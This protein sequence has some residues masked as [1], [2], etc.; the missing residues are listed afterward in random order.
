L[1]LS[2]L[3]KGIRRGLGNETQQAVEV[4]W[5]EPSSLL[6]RLLVIAL[7]DI[8]VADLPTLYA[9]IELTTRRSWRRRSGDC[10]KSEV[11]RLVQAMCAAT[12]SR[13]ADELLAIATLEP[14]LGLSR[15]ELQHLSVPDR[16]VRLEAARSDIGH[17]ALCAWFQAGTRR[18]PMEGVAS[19][20]G[21]AAH[22]WP[23]FLRLGVPSDFVAMLEQAARRC[24]WPLPI[25]LPF[26]HLSKAQ[27]TE[28]NITRTHLSSEAYRSIPLYALDQFTRR[29]RTAIASWLANS[30]KLRGILLSAAHPRRWDRLARYAVFAVEGQRCAQRLRWPDQ[31]QLLIRSMRAELTGR[32]LDPGAVFDF[33][34][35]AAEH[36]TALNERRRAVIDG[37]RCGD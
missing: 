34:G 11:L 15:S 35:C 27:A 2:V 36:L 4:L 22:M 6:D 29:G 18:Y 25:L 30:T 24:R 21:D 28:T 1:A 13:F 7:E 3:Q 17:R 26:A 23:S 31:D 12:K 10:G 8:G 33:L 20:T 32:G 16:A 19:R 37:E 9:A 5:A 14:E